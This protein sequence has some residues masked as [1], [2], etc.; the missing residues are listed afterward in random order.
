MLVRCEEIEREIADVRGDLILDHAN[1][2]R[3]G[4]VVVS[5]RRCEPERHAHKLVPAP[6]RNKPTIE[7]IS[8]GRRR[9]IV[10]AAHGRRARYT[11]VEPA[12]IV[13]A[14]ITWIRVGASAH[15]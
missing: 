11:T 14:W 6:C 3:D 8:C 9:T 4:I 2:L 5:R 15:A 12:R 10:A 7:P 1:A 13:H